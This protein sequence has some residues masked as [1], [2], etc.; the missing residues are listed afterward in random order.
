MQEIVNANPRLRRVLYTAYAIVGLVLGSTQVGYSAAEL[1]SPAW[2]VVALAVYAFVGTTLG[3][4]ALAKVQAVPVKQG[5]T[6]QP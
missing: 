2:L 5:S 6:D 1:G 3:F 4:T